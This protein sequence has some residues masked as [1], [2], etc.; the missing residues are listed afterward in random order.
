MCTC[1]SMLASQRKTVWVLATSYH[2]V[3]ESEVWGMVSVGGSKGVCICCS[4]RTELA[5]R[6]PKSIA[7]LCSGFDNRF[8][9]CTVKSLYCCTNSSNYISSSSSYNSSYSR[10]SS[11]SSGS[12]YSSYIS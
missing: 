11:Y 12:G 8:D 1:A 3:Y 5:E 6:T 4:C 10:G 9:T 7:C 2:I